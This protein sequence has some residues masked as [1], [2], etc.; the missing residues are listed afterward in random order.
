MIHRIRSVRPLPFFRLCVQ[1]TE[2]VT[3]VYDV[4]TWFTKSEQFRALGNNQ[5]RFLS[6]KMDENGCGVFWDDQI[7]LSCDELFE[8]GHVIETR[9]DGL[10]SFSDATKMWNLNE[11]T[12]RKAVTYGKLLDGVDAC[13][14][15]R[16]WVVT[17]EAMEREYGE[18]KM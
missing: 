7:K 13:K 4:A 11:S 3:K 6:V 9:F 15:G 8:N 16:Q 14:F 5:K 1:F 12:L 10:I 2:G 18:P 17:M